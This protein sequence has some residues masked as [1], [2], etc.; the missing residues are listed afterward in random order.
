MCVRMFR[1]GARRS[2]TP[3]CVSACDPSHAASVGVRIRGSFRWP[4]VEV[5]AGKGKGKGKGEGNDANGAADGRKRNRS[6]AAVA[7]SDLASGVRV[8]GRVLAVAPVARRRTARS[9]RA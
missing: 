7:I 2:A 4:L 3:S 9:P 8:S 6:G 1:G 5:P